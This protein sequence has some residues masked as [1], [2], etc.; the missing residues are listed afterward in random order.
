[1]RLMMQSAMLATVLMLSDVSQALSVV[2][3]SR[4]MAEVQVPLHKSRVMQL[5]RPIKRISVGNPEIAD[6]LLTQPN[7][8]LVLGKTLGSTNVMAWDASG[9][10]V[11]AFDVAI[12][13]DLRSIKEKLHELLPNEQVHVSA[14]HNAVVLSGHVSSTEA[15]DTASKIAQSYASAGNSAKVGKKNRNDKKT[16]ETLV[17]LLSVG[18]SHQVMLKVKV[19]EMQRSLFKKFDM[20]FKTLN[21]RSD[22]WSLGGI[23]GGASFPDA[24]LSDG[25]TEM[26]YPVLGSGINQGMWGPAISEIQTNPM[27][28]GDKGLFGGFLTENSFFMFSL[29]AAKNA[30]LAKILAEP[31]LSTMTGQEASFLSG[32]EFPIPVSQGED[33]ITVSYKD[34]GVG[35]NFL[36]TVLDNGRINMRLNVSVSEVN[37]TNTVAVGVEGTNTAFVIP[38]LT[39]RSTSSSVELADGQTMAIAGLLNENMRDV[40]NKFPFLGDLPV[41]G[42][43]F[44]SKEFQKGETELVILVTPQLARPL[45]PNAIQLPTDRYVE[46]ND[47]QFYLMGKGVHRGPAPAAQST[48]TSTP[49][50]PANA[51]SSGRFGHDIA[52]H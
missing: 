28:I 19:A 47:W 24:L 6:I 15:L 4:A 3:D 25:S 31:T 51:A 18:E 46:P 42:T 2:N 29:D 26:E 44:R 23:N 48:A 50:E 30:G 40:V 33:G 43:L 8:V 5:D 35:L 37:A 1:M 17:N 13:Y 16:Q 7:E 32:G 12:T 49:V 9:N 22:N 36:P 34:F 39:K 20:R 27:S 52:A 14:V 10:L 45:D 41:L 21:I 11:A 38:G